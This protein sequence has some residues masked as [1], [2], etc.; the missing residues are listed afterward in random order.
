MKYDAENSTTV[1]Y[2]SN[3]PIT[4]GVP[5]FL[6]SRTLTVLS[7]SY[8]YVTSPPFKTYMPTPKAPPLSPMTH[9]IMPSPSE[10]PT[11]PIGRSEVRTP[12]LDRLEN[13]LKSCYVVLVNIV[14]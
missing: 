9:V 8:A 5:R 7:L 11:D 2:R 4:D 10:P 6:T 13:L 1:L 12:P 3:A 14:L